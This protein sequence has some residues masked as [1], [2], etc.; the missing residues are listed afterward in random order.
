MRLNRC[1]RISATALCVFAWLSDVSAQNLQVKIVN[2]QNSDTSY[3]AVI[4]GHSN[5]TTNG[6]LSCYGGS[7]NVNCSG[8][9]RTTGYNTPSREVTYSV[10]GATLTL[11]LPDGRVAIVNCVSKYRPRGDYI[12]RRSCRMPLV[13]AIGAEF[14]G[15]DAKLRWAV[16]LDGKKL[17]SET[18][19]ILAVLDK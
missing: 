18:Y 19:K 1:L 8:S 15:K 2:R 14:K 12:N 11:L 17:E 10:T 3:S 13:D 6:D 9:A 4:P 16:S 7:T 5:S